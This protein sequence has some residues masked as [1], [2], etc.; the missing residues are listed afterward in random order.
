MGSICSLCCGNSADDIYEDEHNDKTNLLGNPVGESTRSASQNI[1]NKH[2]TNG[3]G[4]HQE[5]LNRILQKTANSYIDVPAL[6]SS[7]EQTTDKTKD[8][9]SKIRENLKKHEYTEKSNLLEDTPQIER[10]LSGEPLSQDDCK[11]VKEVSSSI[12][13]AL[14][15][16]QVTNSENLVIPF[17]APKDNP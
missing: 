4:D 16:I 12:L 10:T 3:V 2:A 8:Y 6:N 13:D 1:S 5:K 9:E 14:Q 11:M 7:V 15:S 17:N